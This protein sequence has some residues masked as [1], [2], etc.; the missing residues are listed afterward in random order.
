MARNDYEFLDYC[1]VKN[2]S[3]KKITSY[4]QTKFV[5]LIFT[6]KCCIVLNVGNKNK[7]CGD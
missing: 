1:L 3:K 6:N 4:E 2:L 7:Q 5:N